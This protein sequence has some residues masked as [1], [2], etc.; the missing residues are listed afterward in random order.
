MEDAA[1][2][3]GISSEASASAMEDEEMGKHR[4]I[5]FFHESTQVALDRLGFVVDG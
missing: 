2:A 3:T 5:P 1:V 4:P